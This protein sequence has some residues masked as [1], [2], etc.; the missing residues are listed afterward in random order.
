LIVWLELIDW[1]CAPS[2][3]KIGHYRGV[4]PSQSLSAVHTEETKPNTTN[5]TYDKSF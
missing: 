3:A 2:D 5:H 1:F 4:L